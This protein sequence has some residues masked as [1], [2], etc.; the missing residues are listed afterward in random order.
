MKILKIDE[1]EFSLMPKAP[2]DEKNVCSD[3]LLDAIYD[4]SSYTENGK[5]VV[6]F[7]DGH[8][9][10]VEYS[11]CQMSIIFNHPFIVKDGIKQEWAIEII[12]RLTGVR[13]ASEQEHAFILD[14]DSGI[15][16]SVN[17]LTN[18]IIIAFKFYQQ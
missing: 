4:N 11:G 5:Q 9:T 7:A 14:E 18:M 2:I 6:G 12:D 16:Y 3:V 8:S 10:F 13:F 15:V 17:C 1:N